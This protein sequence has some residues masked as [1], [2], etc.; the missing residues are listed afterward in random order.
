MARPQLLSPVP[1]SEQNTIRDDESSTVPDT[2][3]I[4]PAETLAGG[5]DMDVVMQEDSGSG[6][7]QTYEH[8]EGNRIGVKYAGPNGKIK[9]A[10]IS[11]H[12]TV[13]VADNGNASFL[14]PNLCAFDLYEKVPKKSSEA[15][16]I[17]VAMYSEFT[18]R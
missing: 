16:N 15:R 4:D 3:S 5:D 11:F 6:L 17:I 13:R 12:P 2:R 18:F 10:Y 9:T 7:S 14:P 1:T 8:I